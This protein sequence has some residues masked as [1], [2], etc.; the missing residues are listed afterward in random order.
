MFAI[1][2][3]SRCNIS[4]P[5]QVFQLRCKSWVLPFVYR[6]VP[7]IV[8]SLYRKHAFSR[9]DHLPLSL[10]RNIL[11]VSVKMVYRRSRSRS[12][13]I[14]RT[15]RRAPRPRSRPIRRRSRSRSR[16]RG[17]GRAGIPKRALVHAANEVVANAD[18]VD[19]ERAAG[20]GTRA[21]VEG[22]RSKLAARALDFAKRYGP[23]AGG[24]AAGYFAHKYQPS[25]TGW[26]GSQVPTATKDSLLRQQYVQGADKKF[27]LRGNTSKPGYDSRPLQNRFRP[28]PYL[29]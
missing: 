14:S 29:A 10:F 13:K 17:R 9:A 19:V 8:G 4:T 11:S 6:C 27:Y 3:C 18:P 26:L 21:Q 28:L 25:V 22:A 2:F 16:S 23:A 24:L 15:K 1:R 12:R 20:N 5:Y 7:I